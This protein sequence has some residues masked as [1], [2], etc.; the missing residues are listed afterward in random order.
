[1]W[2]EAGNGLARA[3]RSIEEAERNVQTLEAMIPAIAAKGYSTAKV[4]QQVE[5]LQQILY[6]LK[7]Q[8]WQIEGMLGTP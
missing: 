3:D 6:H 7:S 2:S 8:R 1:M 4:E 5:V